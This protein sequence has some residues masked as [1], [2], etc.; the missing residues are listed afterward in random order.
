MAV[1]ILKVKTIHP[2]RDTRLKIANIATI[3]LN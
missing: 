1:D 3:M 2:E